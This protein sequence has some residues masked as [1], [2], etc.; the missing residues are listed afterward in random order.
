MSDARRFCKLWC[1]WNIGLL[2]SGQVL[3]IINKEKLFEP[4]MTEEWDKVSEVTEEEWK[5]LER[6]A[7]LIKKSHFTK[8]RDSLSETKKGEDNDM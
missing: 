4:I 6:E 3:Y 2:D 7:T 5:Q 1:F 8:T